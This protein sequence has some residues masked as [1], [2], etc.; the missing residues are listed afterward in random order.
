MMICTSLITNILY[1][2][3]EIMKDFEEELKDSF[4]DMILDG[5]KEKCESVKQLMDKG[6]SL[7]DAT[8]VY[9]IPPELVCALSDIEVPTKKYIVPVHIV[10]EGYVEVDAVNAADAVATVGQHI[11]DIKITPSKLTTALSNQSE[12]LAAPIHDYDIV[13]ALSKANDKG[14]FKG[15]LLEISNIAM[16]LYQSLDEESLREFIKDSISD[17]DDDCECDC[18]DECNECDG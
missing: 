4:V 11:S 2:K 13:N 5:A 17:D 3:E 15:K 16:S 9:D 12:I 7:E 8:E 1:N 18:C 14:T 10:T 6:V